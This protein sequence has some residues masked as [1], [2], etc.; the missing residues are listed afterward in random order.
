MNGRGVTPCLGC[1]IPQ[2]LGCLLAVCIVSGCT[3]GYLDQREA[4][5]R[6]SASDGYEIYETSGFELKKRE[7]AACQFA[8]S[9]LARV[10]RKFSESKDVCGFVTE[11]RHLIDGICSNRIAAQR[12]FSMSL[13][14]RDRLFEYKYD[15]QDRF[16]SGVL[17]LRDGRIVAKHVTFEAVGE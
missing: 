6:S 7:E 14:D 17:I 12:E 4:F 8:D 15:G 2:L 1:G 3:I 11:Q 5:L 10:A 16:E 13:K 9:M